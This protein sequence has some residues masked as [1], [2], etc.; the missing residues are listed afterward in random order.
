M[1]ASELNCE[2]NQASRSA[3]LVLNASRLR[4]RSCL[5]VGKCCG[6]C[7]GL[8]VSCYAVLAPE[9]KCA[10]FR[11]VVRDW[12]AGSDPITN[13]PAGMG[14]VS[15]VMRVIDQHSACRLCL[16]RFLQQKNNKKKK[17]AKHI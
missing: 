3:M 16:A 5:A 15:A 7:L 4:A 13:S 17:T 8:P 12:R 10:S 2:G 1:L 14:L 11:T 6:A 9:L